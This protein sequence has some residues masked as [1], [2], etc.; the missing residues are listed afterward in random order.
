M[1][2]QKKLNKAGKENKNTTVS[3]DDVTTGTFFG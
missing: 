2:I 3:L 1:K